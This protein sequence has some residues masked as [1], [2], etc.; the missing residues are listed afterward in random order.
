[1]AERKRATRLTVRERTR[2]DR[3][4]D[5][6][7][8]HKLRHE[9]AVTQAKRTWEDTKF[10]PGQ[11]R[12]PG[13]GRQPGSTNKITNK[14]KAA[15]DAAAA[16][17]GFVHVDSSGIPRATA[18]GDWEGYFTFLAL[19]HPNVFMK[20]MLTI[21]VAELNGKQIKEDEVKKVFK[22]VDEMRKRM[23]ERGIPIP[24]HLREI[25]KAARS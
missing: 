14:V 24:P 17:C 5:A 19:H 15:V 23:L 6:N 11:P 16:R 18:I 7:D 2:R 10:K 13:A 9:I 3:L 4:K 20:A 22:S 25:T 1:M 8:E 12:P 21:T